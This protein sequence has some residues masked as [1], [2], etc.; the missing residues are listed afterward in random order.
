MPLPAVSRAP[1]CRL[2]EG[3]TGPW[4]RTEWETGYRLDKVAVEPDLYLRGLRGLDVDDPEAVCAFVREYG[5]VAQVG[6]HDDPELSGTT[7]LHPDAHHVSRMEAE[8]REDEAEDLPR[9][10]FIESPRQVGH[11]LALIRDLTT[12]SLVMTEQMPRDEGHAL[13]HPTL[14]N[15]R[16]I[17]EGFEDD[18]DMW[19]DGD[20]MEIE[21]THL[22]QQLI[23]HLLRDFHVTVNFRPVDNP[24][25]MDAIL[26]DA[27]LCL[28]LANDLADGAEFKRCASET[29]GRVFT[30]H[31][32]RA[33]QGKYHMTGVKYC[34]V[35]CA[36]AQKQREYRRRQRQKGAKP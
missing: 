11:Q 27:V 8:R 10:D 21:E 5:Y 1:R 15:A 33:K 7:Y 30:R 35:E 28:S 20:E 2:W 23:G 18:E 31:S 25:E 12:L 4:I 36:R 13:L 6:W 24:W 26:L 14:T 17:I 22:T 19:N 3:R 9:H 29:C 34:S 16:G 32:G